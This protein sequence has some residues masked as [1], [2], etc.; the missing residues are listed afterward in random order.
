MHLKKK[1]HFRG[2]DGGVKD[3]RKDNNPEVTGKCIK[4][5]EQNRGLMEN[6]MWKE[7]IIKLKENVTGLEQNWLVKEKYD[8]KRKKSW[9]D[10]EILR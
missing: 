6:I 4:G 10:I 7:E 3:M 5:Q 1:K 9:S 8:G 2:Q